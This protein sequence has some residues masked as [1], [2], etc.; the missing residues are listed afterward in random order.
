MNGR[1]T[2][3]VVEGISRTPKKVEVDPDGW[4]LLKATVRGEK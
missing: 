3:Q 2:R 1:Q 4:W